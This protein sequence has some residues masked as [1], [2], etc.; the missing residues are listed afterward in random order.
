MNIKN[1]DVEFI[2][3]SKET[4]VESIKKM[5]IGLMPLIDD[6]FQRY[7]SALKALQYM[8][9]GIPALVSPIGINSSIVED[10]V[11]GFSLQKLNKIG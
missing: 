5:D 2:P 9:V 11:H 4:E 10:G 7:K 3:W 6:E 1:V 8:A